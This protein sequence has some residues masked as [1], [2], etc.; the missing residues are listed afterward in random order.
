MKGTDL[1][2]EDVIK[3]EYGMLEIMTER[4]IRSKEKNHGNDQRRVENIFPTADDRSG[5]EAEKD[6]QSERAS[7][8]P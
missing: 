6:R 3:N 4:L 8:L 7:I 1:T 2:A 5:A